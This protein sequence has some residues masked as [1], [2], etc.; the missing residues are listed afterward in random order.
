MTYEEV[1]TERF[2]RYD[3]ALSDYLRNHPLFVND[4]RFHW[5][6]QTWDRWHV[7]VAFQRACHLQH[8]ADMAIG[9]LHR[10]G[11][12][13]NLVTHIVGNA[14]AISV[15]CRRRRRSAW[16]EYNKASGCLECDADD[17]AARIVRDILAHQPVEG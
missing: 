7:G 6:H 11:F 2:L 13:T 5:R 12:V 3:T 1:I 16:L 17:L 9:Q 4:G 10:A 8:V 14:L 15:T